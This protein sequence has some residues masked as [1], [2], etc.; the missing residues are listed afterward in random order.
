MQNTI[1]HWFLYLCLCL[2]P[3]GSGANVDSKTAT[4]SASA[5]AKI[6]KTYRRFP[7]ENPLDRFRILK[8][9]G[10]TLGNRP[11]TEGSFDPD[12]SVKKARSRR[13]WRIFGLIVGGLALIYWLQGTIGLALVALAIG[14][15]FFNRK[16]IEQWDRDRYARAQSVD[17]GSLDKDSKGNPIYP[18]N[19]PANKWTRRAINRFAIGLV[20]GGIG[21]VFALLG[22]IFGG[23]SSLGGLAIFGL[24]ALG[25]GYGFSIVGFFNACQAVANKEPKHFFAWLIILLSLPVIISLL[26]FVLAGG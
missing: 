6:A 15:Y 10:P 5:N 17:D 20:L 7:K 22:F 3:L 2:Y 4:H 13:F 18:L 21:I 8:N 23:G 24:L 11:N 19:H 1:Y 16:K 9:T 12:K 26:G 14:L 25:V